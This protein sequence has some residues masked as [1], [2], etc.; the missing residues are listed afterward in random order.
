MYLTSLFPTI[1]LQFSHLAA[2]YILSGMSSLAARGRQVE[3]E[4]EV[5]GS[6]L[7]RE[8]MVVKQPQC[9]RA[10]EPTLLCNQVESR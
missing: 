7:P 4:R 9:T 10:E 5:F 1:P 3:Q 8:P 6:F 2:Q